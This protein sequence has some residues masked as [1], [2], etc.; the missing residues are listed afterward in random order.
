MTYQVIDN[1]LSESEF[2]EIYNIIF[3]DGNPVFE[4]FFSTEVT[5]INID[6][7]DFWS[8]YFSHCFYVDYCP[9]SRYFETITNIFKPKFEKLEGN[10][11]T[12]IRIKA[13]LYPYTK[14]LK[15][16]NS[17]CDYE[18]S[19]HAAVF[20]LN[21]CNGFT[22]ME[23][24]TK[25]DSVRNRIVIFDAGKNHNSTTTSNSKFRANINFNWL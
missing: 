18:F 4:W 9:R 22:R 23:D 10:F 24:G 15:E 21:T 3:N 2:K 17:H 11:K 8:T 12:W 6:E 13:N 20:S 25:V 7:E 16:H 19:H 5:S 14:S 1:F